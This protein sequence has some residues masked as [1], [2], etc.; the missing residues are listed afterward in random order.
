MTELAGHGEAARRPRLTTTGPID[1]TATIHFTVDAVSTDAD[2]T[3]NAD[4]RSTH[5]NARS[6]ADTGRSGT[7]ATY[8]A[9]AA[10]ARFPDT[11]RWRAVSITVNR[12]SSR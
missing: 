12:G 4:T 9:H 11:A 6:H 5:A 2:A 3:L 1:R 7:N 10:R 8:Y